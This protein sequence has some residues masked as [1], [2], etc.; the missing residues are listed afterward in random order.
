M[1]FM[2]HDVNLVREAIEETAKTDPERC[3]A[4]KDELMRA[5]VAEVFEVSRV[6]SSQVWKRIGEVAHAALEASAIQP[7]WEASA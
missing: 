5:V 7:K 1:S 6:Q 3:H 2:M 4:L